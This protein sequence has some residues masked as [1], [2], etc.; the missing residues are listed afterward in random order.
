M[1]EPAP[2]DP[3][4]RVR[5]LLLS[6]DNIIKNRDAPD[7]FDRARERYE[8]AREIASS[9]GLGSDLIALVDR[10]LEGLPGDAA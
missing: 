6:G 10:R 4:A 7:R 5:Q 9:A 3:A 2:P 8:R 1:D